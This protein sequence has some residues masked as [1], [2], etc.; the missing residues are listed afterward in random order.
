VPAWTELIGYAGS[1]LVVASLLMGSVLRLR[2]IGLAGAGVFAAYALLIGSVPVLVTN[3]TII[4]VHGFHLRRLL[5]D[6]AR[7]A[8]FEVVPWR[9]T[10]AYV[11]RFLSFW[12]EDI[13][14]FQPAFEGLRDDHSAFVVLRD[15]VPVGLVLFRHLDG[16]A[17][18]D[19]DYVTPPHRDF[20]A[21]A[22]VFAS[23]G[24]FPARGVERVE[25]TAETDAHRR[26]LERVGFERRGRLWTLE[27]GRG[28][29]M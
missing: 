19:L 3:L 13:A 2:L 21:A 26:Y 20:R 9:M 24:P 14:R 23:D 12:A 5:H 6:R 8:Y 1:A 17:R 11:P 27:L 4:A 16:R 15:A 25:T 28:P 10:G 7:T 18:I 29:T 22:Y